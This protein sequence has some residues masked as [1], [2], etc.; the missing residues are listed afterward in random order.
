METAGQ[1]VNR[2][3]SSICEVEVTDLH[4]ELILRRTRMTTITTV[5]KLY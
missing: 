5:V 4:S 2:L 3:N 1:E